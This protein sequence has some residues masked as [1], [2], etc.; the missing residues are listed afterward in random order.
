MLQRVNK[1]KYEI[2]DCYMYLKFQ[3]EEVKDMQEQMK[4][5]RNNDLELVSKQN[6]Q[7]RQA[8]IRSSCNNKIQYHLYQILDTYYKESQ[9]DQRP[10][11]KKLATYAV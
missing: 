11:I 6:E 3:D 10:L 8:F 7:F 1:L 9:Q 4:N 5:I 2:E